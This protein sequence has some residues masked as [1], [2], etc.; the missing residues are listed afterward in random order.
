[1]LVALQH[2]FAMSMWWFLDVNM[3]VRIY[4]FAY[5]YACV[6]ICMLTMYVLVS[7]RIDYVLHSHVMSCCFLRL[8][9]SNENQTMRIQRR[10]TA[11][12]VIVTFSFHV[13]K[14]Y[15]SYVT[16]SRSQQETL[17]GNWCVRVHV[18]KLYATVCTKTAPR[19][20][21]KVGYD[22]SSP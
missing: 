19:E 5:V 14:C 13:P 7:V 22:V 16:K 18:Q 2:L 8:M 9:C 6:Y 15:T 1:M 4:V 10:S 20:R 12:N 11:L 17:T 21:P 3:C